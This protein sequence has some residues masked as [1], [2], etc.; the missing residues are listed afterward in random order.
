LT[1]AARQALRGNIVLELKG[2]KGRVASLAFSADG[3]L[4]ASCEELGDSVWIWDLRR[5]RASNH[6]RHE[7][8]GVRQISFAP[9]GTVLAWAWGDQLKVWDVA[10][11]SELFALYHGLQF[12]HT[13][14]ISKG[15]EEVASRKPVG[16]AG[17][18]IGVRGWDVSAG[19]VLRLFRD[20]P[21]AFQCLAVSIGGQQVAAGG[22]DHQLTVWNT[23][24]PLPQAT[25]SLGGS[26]KW[27]AYT[28]DGS[29]LAALADWSVWLLD[30]ATLAPR[31][32][33]QGR[34][35]SAAFSHD[36]QTLATGGDDGI[37]RFWNTATGQERTHFAWEIG[38]IRTVAFSRD[39]TRAAAGC[40][41]NILVWDVA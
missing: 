24:D 19:K 5:A 12:V 15:G 18:M 37:V 31:S 7:I 32:V 38:K 40:D 36:G 28:P 41:G 3:E 34:A 6:L 10:S 35:M 4:L 30:A 27:V 26:L 20:R 14:E 1:V 8:Y 22:E 17:P 13:L 33:A 29:T 9:Q 21:G 2:H 11:G 25:H 39:G 23:G 16:Y